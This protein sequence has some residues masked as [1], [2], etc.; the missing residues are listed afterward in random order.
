MAAHLTKDDVDQIVSV[1]DGWP[2]GTTLTWDALLRR[3]ERQQ[4]IYSTRQTFS[5]HPAI[6]LAFQTRKGTL[7]SER[8]PRTNES[9]LEAQNRA[10]RAENARLRKE[11]DRLMR[12]FVQWLRNAYKHGLRRHHLEEPLPRPR[13]RRSVLRV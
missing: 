12:V 13:R 9:L 2:V 3:C 6:K 7:R 1:I 8:S 5:R 4:G 10:L 11:N